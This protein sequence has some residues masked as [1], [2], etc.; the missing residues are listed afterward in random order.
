M[1]SPGTGTPTNAI[2]I[3][4]DAVKWTQFSGGGTL[5]GAAPISIT[6]NVVSVGLASTSAV[7]VASFPTAQFTVAT[8]GA[9]SIS[10]LAGSVVSGNITGNA[11]NVTGV[12]ALTNGGTNATTAPL[13][14]AAL[15]AAE[16]GANSDITSLSGL[17][18]ALSIAQGGTSAT[19]APL[20][21]TALGLG[22]TST[23]RFGALGVNGTISTTA[24]KILQVGISD[25]V[26][27]KLPSTAG[28]VNFS[29]GVVN[30]SQSS[31]TDTNGVGVSIGAPTFQP[32]SGSHTITDAA[33]LYISGAPSAGT[34]QTITN[35]WALQTPGNIKAGEFYGSGANLTSL[36]ASNITGTLP[37]ANGGTNATTAPLARAS[38]S[39]AALGANTDIT[40]LGGLTTALSISQGGTSATTAPLARAAL[41]ATTKLTGTLDFSA[42]T[43][44][45][46]NHGLGNWV[47]AQSFDGSGYI[48]DMD[49]QNTS[50][51]GGTTIYTV[52]ATS[53]TATNFTYV[54]VG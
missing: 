18:T 42:T 21:A 20:A 36:S 19:T 41:G 52:S 54:I 49:V 26:A 7:G 47:T 6:D 39:A 37:L 25:S 2:K 4:T 53:A 50:A 34:A 48:I 51:S 5:A 23:T 14:R 11:A 30:H 8:T 22:T 24:G 27:G 32:L 38:L 28:W 17:T 12:I 45:S 29:G 44:A 10:A 46:V 40:S 3:G 33:T 43:V 1:N 15:S 31:G 16:S 9:V 35:S 13:A